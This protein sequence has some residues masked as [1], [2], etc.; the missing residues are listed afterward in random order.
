MTMERKFKGSDAAFIE[1]AKTIRNHLQTYHADFSAFDPTL[2]ATFIEALTAAI[3]EVDAG[4][5]DVAHKEM[6]RQQTEAVQAAMDQ[7]RTVYK[8]LKYFVEQTFSS[9][10]VQ[11]EFGLGQFKTVR[12]SQPKMIQFMGTLKTTAAKYSAQLT[13]HGC[14]ADLIA[15]IETAIAALDTA[16][17]GQESAKGERTV[18]TEVRVE[19]LN[20]VYDRLMRVSAAAKIV[21]E[22]DATRLALFHLKNPAA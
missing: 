7:C 20:A 6:V 8:R 2:D 19:K 3:A 11:N 10:G 15:S 12:D 13:A 1:Q 21:F 14:P 16:N 17:Q 9:K 5:D 18:A 22:G 4:R